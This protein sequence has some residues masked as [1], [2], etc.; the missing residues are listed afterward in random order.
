MAKFDF[1]V[2]DYYYGYCTCVKH[3][4]N[5]F[6]KLN[7]PLSLAV[8]KGKAPTQVNHQSLVQWQK[9]TLSEGSNWVQTFIPSEQMIKTDP[10]SEILY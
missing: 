4:F 2:Y 7:L 3:F 1:L 8:K 6:T 10:V 5:M 9:L